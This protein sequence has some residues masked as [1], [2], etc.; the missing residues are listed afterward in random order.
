MT[1]VTLPKALRQGLRWV[2]APLSL[3]VDRN[4]VKS[5][6]FNFVS[7]DC[8]L[9]YAHWFDE[10][11]FEKED[12][13]FFHRKFTWANIAHEIGLFDSVSEAR[14]RGWG[15]EIEQG[16]SEAVFQRNSGAFSFV[17]ILNQA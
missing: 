14:K 4:Q 17:F 12:C 2:G 13:I 9:N 11:G 5:G 15:I 3:I 6:V 1:Q 7:D 10:F 8:R 16:Y